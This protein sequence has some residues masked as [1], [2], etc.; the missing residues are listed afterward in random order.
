VLPSPSDAAWAAAAGLA[1]GVGITAL[2]Q[3][4]ASGRM[5]VVAPATGVIAASVPV[6][7]GIALQGSPGE[8][9]LAGILLAFVAVVLV[10]RAAGVDTGR[11]GGRAQQ[12]AE[13]GSLGAGSRALAWL[14]RDGLGLGLLAGVGFGLFN[15][16]AS[17][18]SAGAV[19]GP[20]VLVRATEAVLI[21]V[22]AIVGGRTRTLPRAVWPIVL[23]V[24]VL[25]MTGNGTYILAVQAGRLDVAAVLSSLYPVTTVVLATVLLR[26]HVTR[27]HALGIFVAVLA[28]VLIAGG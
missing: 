2:Y 5:G 25:D 3:G 8:R 21:A 16:F 22:V 7:V 4:L 1:G 20:I 14:A 9:R 12:T 15:V 27:G 23:A 17:R 11:P 10:S 6:L 19:F 13:R 18:F 26:E 24:G 28:I